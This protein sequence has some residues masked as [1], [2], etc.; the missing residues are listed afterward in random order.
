M[1]AG[2]VDVTKIFTEQ[3]RS[4]KEQLIA[5]LE[6]RLL[7]GDMTAKQ[8]KTVREYLD[9]KTTLGEGDIRDAIRLVM[10][11]PEYQVT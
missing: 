1:R 2:G 9:S 5:A 6:K 8:E 3:E 11:T 4:D 7:Q 10:C